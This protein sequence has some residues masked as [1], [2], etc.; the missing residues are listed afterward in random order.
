M[1]LSKFW[2]DDRV[3][4]AILLAAFSLGL[5]YNFTILPGLA[6]D[7][8]RHFAY[9]RLLWEEHRFPFLLPNGSEYRGAHSLHPPLYYLLLLPF[10]GALHFLPEA[11]I[12][13]G[14]RLISSLLCVLSLPLIYDVAR[15]ADGNQ[16]ETDQN[17]KLWTARLT[18]ALI[19]LVPIFGMTS[20]SV[21]NDSASVLAVALFLWLL[22]RLKPEIT[23]RDAAWLGLIF[24]LGTLCKA[25]VALCDGAA[26]LAFLWA[27]YGIRSSLFWRAF[28]PS[29]FVAVMVM[30]P[31]YARNFALYGKFS[32]IESGFSSPALPDP[33]QGILVMMMH[34]N[35]P[36]LFGYAN[37]GIF[38]SLWSQKDW[39]PES[40]RTAVYLG[41]VA[42]VIVGALGHLKL[43]RADL[44]KESADAAARALRF[45]LYAALLLNWAACGAMALFVHWGWAEGGRY[46]VA[47]F[48]ALA[49]FCARGWNAL[50]PPKI[51]FGAL[52]TLFL[53]LNGVCI[54]WLLSYLNPTFGPK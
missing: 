39:I 32:P 51:A 43:R 35:F 33:S 22:S 28:L 6:P 14:L 53:A 25:T 17:R 30:L 42:L 26:L 1:R 50:V 44:S 36:T 49:F 7:E 8:P 9:V 13:H 20:G 10:Y 4:G 38:T 11:A 47:A 31:W 41:F 16:S 40:V 24:G 18:C 5:L 15:G 52:S 46:L 48:A 21:N 19:A 23:L 45:S 37:W 29:F 34:P 2:R 27:R 12:Y 54:F 3:L